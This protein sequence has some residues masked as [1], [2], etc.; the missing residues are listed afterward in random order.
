[1][2]IALLAP[3]VAPIAEPFLGGAQSLLRD[4]AVGLAARGHQVTLY[5]ARGSDAATLPGVRL[6]AL[7]VDS[8]ELRPAQF[9]QS[10][11]E[12][13]T[14]ADSLGDVDQAATAT[15]RAFAHAYAVIANSAGKHDLL[16]AHAYDLPAFTL[17]D[18]QPLPV[19]HTLHLPAVDAAIR[20][21]LGTLAPL[22]SNT[23]NHASPWIITVSHACAATYTD[24]CRMDAVIY[25]GIAVDDI[26][27]GVAPALHGQPPEP[28]LLYA[29][30]ITPE[31]GVEDALAIANAAGYRLLMVGA[32]YNPA[33]YASRVAPRLTARAVALG[34]APREQ[35][36]TLMAGA[37]AVLC[38]AQWDEPFGLVACEAQAAG[39]PVIGYARGGLVEVVANG[40]TGYL[41]APGDRAAAAAAVSSVGRLDRAACRRHV[42]DRF[43]LS[44]MLDDYE[45]FYRRM[46]A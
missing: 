28:Y 36:W 17:A 25:N 39:A 38:P 40:E 37:L 19:V 13:D 41:L 18:R 27:F 7:D 23:S 9:M 34:P 31:K 21:A 11:P 8:G 24:F 6:V 26:P 35:L 33:Y 32:V 43:S 22:R 1:M 20:A 44:R 4:L 45:A 12:P 30:R 14:L 5:A 16:H 42:T 15:E 10:D 29:G 46:L 3:L 2:R